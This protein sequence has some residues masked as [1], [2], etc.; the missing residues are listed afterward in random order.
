MACLPQIKTI[1]RLSSFFFHPREIALVRVY[2]FVP[3]R[4]VVVAAA[5]V[6]TALEGFWV[7]LPS[8]VG[9]HMTAEPMIPWKKSP[10][11]YFL[12]RMGLLCPRQREDE[13][14]SLRQ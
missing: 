4:V 11:N 9:H 2:P 5:A 14:M 10:K 8:R 3:V 7:P 1:L 6:C 13:G 12:Q